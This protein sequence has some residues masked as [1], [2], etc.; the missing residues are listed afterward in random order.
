MYFDFKIL[1]TTSFHPKSYKPKPSELVSGG[2]WYTYS[3]HCHGFTNTY[4]NKS[5]GKIYAFVYHKVRKKTKQTKLPNGKTKS[6]VIRKGGW[7]VSIYT[8]TLA[9]LEVLGIKIIQR[10][11]HFEV[12]KV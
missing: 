1:P 8:F 4:L 10:T 12:V 6:V 11:R 3:K 7:N 2:L 5:D 9:Q